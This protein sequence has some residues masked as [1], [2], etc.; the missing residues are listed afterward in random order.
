MRAWFAV[1]LVALASLSA[2][3][4]ASSTPVV[5]L[6]RTD[7]ALRAA[8]ELGADRIPRAALHI[9][10]AEDQRETARRFL[11]NGEEDEAS[12]A[13]DRAAS[14]AELA[15][16]LAKEQRAQRNAEEIQSRAA[17]LR[18]GFTR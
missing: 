6:N 18:T 12:A 17:S 1:P 4:A 13:L 5:E 9:K 8:H 11:A 10:M 14:D 15:V 2:G 3:C 16:A 7:A